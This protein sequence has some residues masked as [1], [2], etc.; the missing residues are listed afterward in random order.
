MR[1]LLKSMNT[2]CYLLL[3]TTIRDEVKLFKHNTVL[4]VGTVGD[5]KTTVTVFRFYFVSYCSRV[6]GRRR[7]G[8]LN[9][10]QVGSVSKRWK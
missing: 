8:V 2:L 1:K 5:L 10:T 6:P 9:G 7:K 4:F 3:T